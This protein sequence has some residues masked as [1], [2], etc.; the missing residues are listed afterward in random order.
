MPRPRP[1]LDPC[2][3]W[4]C[5]PRDLGAGAST[6]DPAL[7]AAR[8]EPPPKCLV[9]VADDVLTGAD[10]SVPPEARPTPHAAAVAAR[11]ATGLLALRADGSLLDQVLGVHLV[12][13]DGARAAAACARRPLNEHGPTFPS[14]TI[15]QPSPSI[16]ARFMGLAAGLVTRCAKAA[17]AAAPAALDATHTLPARAP[18]AALAADALALLGVT[19][20]AATA[21]LGGLELVVAH[22]GASLADVETVL[23]AAGSAA[24]PGSLLV[25]L[26]LGG[27]DL[28]LPARG[29]E[30]LPGLPGVR[31]PLQ[32]FETD[33]DGAIVPL[34][35]PGGAFV[36]VRLRGVT[37]NDPVA[38]LDAASARSCGAL[39]TAQ[40]DTLLPD[41]A[42]KLGRLAKYGA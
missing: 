21:P 4:D 3:C 40:A 29:G 18:A 35:T 37:R 36:A 17:A 32:S 23:R 19:G 6:P 9:V 8:Q 10:G 15:L 20:N 14:P 12:S 5:E 27:P 31:R 24:A 7:A 11:G 2:D 26:V 39:H 28:A 42:F 30:P 1:R 34:A 22:C 13:F 41:L 33:G 16:P 38:S 25:A